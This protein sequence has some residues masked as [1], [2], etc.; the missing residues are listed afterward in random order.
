MQ[1]NWRWLRVNIILKSE[2]AYRELKPCMIIFHPVFFF[3]TV[4]RHNARQQN[5]KESFFNRFFFFF[6]TS[7]AEDILRFGILH[8]CEALFM[9]ISSKGK[10][11]GH[12]L[13]YFKGIYM[14]FELGAISIRKVIAHAGHNVFFFFFVVFVCRFFFCYCCLQET[15]R[16]FDVE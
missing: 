4:I 3:T 11:F 16:V 6:L 7:I 5:R 10:T 1:R 15:L 2:R 14:L 9:V 12:E 13:I 8:S